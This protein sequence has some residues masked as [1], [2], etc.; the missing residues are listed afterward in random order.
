MM[1]SAAIR[2]LTPVLHDI[3]VNNGTGKRSDGGVDRGGYGGGNG[4]PESI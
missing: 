2:E 3:I 4:K 1:G